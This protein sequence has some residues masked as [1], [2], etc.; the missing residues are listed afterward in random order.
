LQ[1]P[2]AELFNP[3]VEEDVAFG[4]L[5]YGLSRDEISEKV[6][7]ILSLMNLR[8][9][10][11][12]SSHHLSYGEKK[13]VALATVLVMQPEVV[14]FDEPF[15]NLDPAM[16]CQLMKTIADI[17]ATVIL[18]SQSILPA[19]SCCQR[20]AVLKDGQV[21]TV[22]SATEIASDNAL[23]RSCGLDFRFYCDICKRFGEK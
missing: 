22:G 5:N 20:L 7:Q 9:F 13:R 10:E 18:V 11:K 2:D 21:V 3:T 6:R 15:S 4:P 23:L 8:G 16:V 1:N 12:M 19:L 17:P 14:A